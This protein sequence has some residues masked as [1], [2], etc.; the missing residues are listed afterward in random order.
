MGGLSGLSG[1]RGLSGLTAKPVAASA[2]DPDA[3]AFFTAANITDVTQQNAVNA[4]A[5]GK[6]ANGT[7]TKD[8]AIYP[9]VGG[10]ALQ[11][12]FNLKNPSQ[13]QITWGGTVTHNANGITGD[14]S[15]GYGNTGFTPSVH[16]TL[17]SNS[18]SLYCRTAKTAAATVEMGCNT[19]SGEW[20]LAIRYPGDSF[21]PLLMSGGGYPSV[22]LAATTGWILASR[23]DTTTVQAYRNGGL[24]LNAAQVQSSLT[25]ITTP[26][27][28]LASRH[29]NPTF[30]ARHSAVN[31]ALASIGLGLT[32]GEITADYT[33]IQA[34]ETALGRQV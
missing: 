12:S 32:A 6:K 19:G 9:F 2:F 17:A 33:T 28:V 11:H 30:W 16:G 14:G 15:T 21:F 13:F 34:Y 1:L 22:A 8:Q 7:W 3:Q 27:A 23:N 5:I 31:L 25:G 20:A 10:T 26:M 4:L 24:V 29:P 18:I